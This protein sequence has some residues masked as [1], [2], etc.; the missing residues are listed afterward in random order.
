[1]S[2]NAPPKKSRS[3]FGF[4][5]LPLFFALL[6]ALCFGLGKLAIDYTNTQSF[7]ISCHEMKDNN[8]V[9]YQDSIHARN[10]TGVKAICS[11][12]HVPH[13]LGPT[14]MRKLGA[15]NDIYHHFAGTIDTREKFEVH[16]LELAERVWRYMKE[17]DSRECRYCHDVKAMDPEK[18]GKTAQKQHQKVL[19]GEK[20]CIDCH[21]GIAHHEPAGDHVPAD[22]VKP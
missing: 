13:A 6:G 4:F 15:V 17:S 20:T 12:C 8:F 16:R 10:R 14:L 22:V 9:E 18:Q 11:D 19:R 5:A 21:Y 3:G 7:C 2:E 1:M